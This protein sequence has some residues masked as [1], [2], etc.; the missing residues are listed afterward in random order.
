[1]P[2]LS[3][4]SMMAAHFRIEVMLSRIISLLQI[5]ALIA[6]PLCCSSGLCCADRCADGLSCTLATSDSSVTTVTCPC[7]P[8]T[9]DHDKSPSAPH[10]CPGRSDC[11]G[12]C[13]G[14][15]FEKPVELSRLYEWS[16]L[17]ITDARVSHTLR[18]LH[19]Q[20]LGTHRHESDDG[21]PSGRALRQWHMSWLC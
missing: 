21:T 13:G 14:A 11:Q 5:A 16:V 4:P 1:M 7:C 19:R 12:V 9:T 3:G 10:Q 2:E 18:L 20:W 17:A 8:T 15:V 6:C